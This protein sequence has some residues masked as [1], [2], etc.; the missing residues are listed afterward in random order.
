PRWR[1][2]L[3]VAAYCDPQIATVTPF[4]NAA[5]AFSVP[6][7]GVNAPIQFPFTPLKMSRLIE[8]LSTRVYPEVP[9]G[10]GFCMFIKRQVLD[11][12]GE[13]DEKNFGRGYGEENDFCMRA[14]RAGW[15]HVIDDSLFVYHRG[16]S[17]FGKEKQRLLVQNRETLNRL[18]PDYTHL[19]REFAESAQINELRGRIGQNLRQLAPEL[20]LEQRRIL[21]ILHEGTGGVPMT[22]AD[23]VSKVSDTHQCFLLTSTGTEMILR[24]WREG[25]A[26]ERQRWRLSGRWSA[27]DFRRPALSEIY[28]QVLVGLGIDLV[29]I[30]HLFKHSFDAPFLCRALGIPTI[31]SFHD[32]YFVCP[33]IH[34]LDQNAKFCGGQCTPGLEQCTIPSGLL[35]D[36][37]MLKPFL[38]QWQERVSQLLD[39]CDAFVTTAESVRDVHMKAFPQLRQKPFWVV[40]HGRDLKRATDM[41]VP[42]RSGEPVRI[43]APGNIGHS[44]GSHFIR[45]IA[46]IDT[47]GLIEFHFLGKTDD[48]VR[49]IGVHHGAYKRENFLRAVSK[50]RPSF[51]AIFSIWAETY[52]HTLTEAWG[53]GLPVF[54]SNLG[55][56][57]ERIAKHGGGWLIDTADPATTLEKIRDIANNDLAYQKAVREVEA[58]RF[59]TV[60]EMASSYCALYAQLLAPPLPADSPRAGCFVPAGDRGSTFL[61]V[62][63]PLAHEEMGKVLFAARLPAADAIGS[64][65]EWIDRLGLTTV[66]LQREALTK[67][68]AV[69]IVET[70]RAQNIRLVFEIDDN[71]LDL[72]PSHIDYAFYKPRTDVIRY[73]AEKADQIVVSTQN[74]LDVFRPLNEHICVIEN[75]VDEWLWF[76]PARPPT[77]SR[78]AGVVVVGYMGTKTHGADLE[79]IREP[80]LRARR[81]LKAEHQIQL[82]LEI[83][84]GLEDDPLA[85]KWY[86]R[87]DVPRG[88]AHYPRFVRWLRETVTWDFALA[89]LRQGSLNHSKSA[90]KFFEYAGLGVSGIF[91]RTGEY[92]R[93]IVD[94][95]TGLL[96]D[97]DAPEAWEAAIVELAT[98]RA[99]RQKLAAGAREETIARHLLVQK[100]PDWLHILKKA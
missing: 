42:P 90:L 96:V 76:Q 44:K 73:L 99:L 26:I 35:K 57:G 25:G 6:E 51:A 83:I 92:P 61:R 21:Y 22:N 45:E 28:F 56:V 15:R 88:S 54:G 93:V 89:P 58:I 29:H 60:E 23:L 40:E 59:L 79:M 9:T 17:S 81:R 85:P 69:T 34:L 95:E 20:Q 16:N 41:A 91:S 38:P 74:L 2:K 64:F 94:R 48:S 72:D 97:P 62:T 27:A 30:R 86:H 4:S 53:A 100:I 55:A 68:D 7:I 37:P 66:F 70:S 71:L 80:F 3:T 1:Q 14:R 87:L 33:S 36:L 19:V 98:S 47:E 77:Q 10:N 67:H 46:R 31:L 11:E 12:V 50:I 84:G 65:G 39:C 78:A 32:Y 18:H 5:G 8:R 63:L 75:T 82:N 24:E 49:D 43:L 13:F 52:S